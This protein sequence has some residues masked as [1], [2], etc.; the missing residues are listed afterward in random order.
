LKE[1]EILKIATLDDLLKLIDLH[2][3]NLRFTGTQS[4]VKKIL[5][6]FNTKEIHV[7]KGKA[8]YKTPTKFKLEK[9]LLEFIKNGIH[10]SH[11]DIQRPTLEEIFIEIAEGRL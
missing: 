8:V 4:V 6:K 5:E 11:L 2:T 9:L 7:E 1:G 10:V 3:H